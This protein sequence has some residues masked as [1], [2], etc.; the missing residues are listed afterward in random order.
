MKV[1][2]DCLIIDESKE[3]VVS[4]I[5][6]DREEIFSEVSIPSIYEGHTGYSHGGIVA[7][8]LDHVMGYAVAEKTNVFIITQRLRIT[9][10]LPILLNKR[11]KVTAQVENLVDGKAVVNAVVQNEKAEQCVVASGLFAY[12]KDVLTK[13]GNNDNEK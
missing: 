11:Y 10:I 3:A 6:K 9:Y 1:I 4:G 7:T 8:I 13:F 12:T 2:E 5:Y